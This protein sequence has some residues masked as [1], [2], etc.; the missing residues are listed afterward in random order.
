MIRVMFVCL[1]NI[2]RSPMAEYVLK[3][4][5]KKRGLESEF[6]I[7]SSAT[8]SEEAGNPV[9]RGTRRILEG[10]NIDCSEK[11]A[12]QLRKSDYEKYDYIL[13]MERANIKNILRI[14][15][16][17]S[18]GK[19]K[20]LLD[21]SQKPRDIADPWYTGNFDATYIDICEGCNAFLNHV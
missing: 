19:V 4:M 8:S 10:M 2:C 20:R 14:V 1:G 18:E 13:A 15:G 3:D 11:R 9:H 16:E 12:V 21:F 7:A 6:F 17:D 5:V